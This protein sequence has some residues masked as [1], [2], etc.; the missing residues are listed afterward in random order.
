MS[1][2]YAEPLERLEACLEELLGV[3]AVFRTTTEKQDLLVRAA[4]ARTRLQA[5]E[6]AVLAVA[7]DIAETTGARTTATWLAETTRDAHGRVRDQ[8]RLGK[9]L[10]TRWH[11]L[12][13][14]FGRGQ[15]N[16]AQVRVIDK[17]L[18][19]LPQA[20]GEDLLGKAETFLVDH[21]SQHGPRELA[22]LGAR[23]L[24]YLAPETAEQAEYARLLAEEDRAAATTRLS[25]HRRGDGTTDIHARLPDHAANRLRAYTDAIANPRRSSHD[26][27]FTALPVERRRG[28]AFQ[29]LLETVLDKDLPQHGQSA[30]S[31][32]VTIPHQTLLTGLGTATTSTGDTI[33][34]GQAR[35]LACQAAILPAILD[36][37]SEVLDL[38]RTS[39]FFKGPLRKAMD[40]RDKECTTRGC[41]VPAAFCHGHHYRQPWAHGGTTSLKDGKL[42]CP[43]HHHRAHHPNWDTHHHPDGTTTYTRRQ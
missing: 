3:E 5:L 43:F 26:D 41:H 2:Q 14:A 21:A 10:E 1:S 9:A 25:F 35:R 39:R 27:D 15:V 29:S 8:A 40:L 20:V 4:R 23:V 19:D 13:H 24:E 12:A 22:V 28:I 32:I 33:T 36:G 11:K 38:G 37:D 42:L 34:A 6:I 31:I 30:T 18:T 7:D 16:L 17:A